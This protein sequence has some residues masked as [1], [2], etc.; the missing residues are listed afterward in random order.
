M[1]RRIAFVLSLVAE[2]LL[3]SQLVRS[4]VAGW[5][6]DAFAFERFAGDPTEDMP[7][8]RRRSSEG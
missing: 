4:G 1:S 8:N 3:S 6:T 2:I 5:A 7:E